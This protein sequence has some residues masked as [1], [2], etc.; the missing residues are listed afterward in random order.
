MKYLKNILIL[1]ILIVVSCTPVF[2][3]KTPY[4]IDHLDRKTQ[5]AYQL[6]HEY[7]TNTIRI[8]Q[9]TKI[10]PYSRIDT[11]LVHDH[12]KQIDVYLNKAFAHIPFREKNTR[13]IYQSARHYLN[14]AFDDYTV[15]LYALDQPIEELI[16][17][18]YRSDVS[19]YDRSR[20]PQVDEPP[21]PLIRNLSQ[22][23][24]VTQG[25]DDRYI[26][27]W[28]SHGWYYEQK[29]DRWEWQRA[30]VFQT[31]EDLFPLSFTI[32]YLMPMLENAGAHVF[33]PRERDVQTHEVIVDNDQANPATKYLEEDGWF[34]G[35]TPGFAVGKPPYPSGTN[36][37]QLG[38][39]RQTEAK[40]QATTRIHWIPEIP[41]KGHYAVY[42]SYH[43]ADSN[44]TDA[45]YT[46]NH[47]GGQT[48]FL[49]NQQMAGKTWI[50][51]GHFLFGKG[52]NPQSGSV[53][54]T[55]AGGEGGRYVT[56]DAVRFGGGMGNIERN[57]KTSGRPRY[58]EAARY[59]LQYAGMPDTL[60][61]NLNG[62]S[63]DY[64]DDYQSRGE[65]V[66]YLKGA[67][68]GPNRNRE[69]EGLGIPID[70]SL[71]FHTDAG[72]S[73]SDTV[74]GTLS[75]YC[76]TGADTTRVFPDSMSRFANRDFAD[77]LQTQIV[78]DIRA[79][80]DTVWTRRP[81]WDRGYSEAYRPNV[82]A[83]LLE[84]LSHQNF[85]DMKFGL[86]PRYRFDVSRSIYKSMLKFLAHQYQ[87]DYVVQPLP[88]SHF[89]AVFSAN[90]EVTLNWQP[91]SDPLEPTAEPDRY[92]VYTRE[93]GKGFD[94]G[95]LTDK[96]QYTIQN[97]DPGKIYS[98]K[99]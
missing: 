74:I 95:V 21:V 96:P 71:A 46:V 28:H 81:L 56:A 19:D 66:N 70:L 93:E 84:L 37:F 36:P 68:Y 3:Q 29:Y 6:M 64:N 41:E 26:A 80:Y 22:P 62:D 39:Y 79:Q 53:M 50:Y 82:P 20:M 12:S 38:S 18:V 1:S 25:L 44:I 78:D 49:I 61:Y 13:L 83:A 40:K 72:T 34:A 17:N 23:Y 7:L 75:I 85:L 16:P 91:V 47:L 45:H 97:L 8:E 55:N 52:V 98:F 35:Y 86:D 63:I 27:L 54:L 42:I 10:S 94:N 76:T 15:T 4:K 90:R 11:I 30:R 65:W 31:V 5:H 48:E 92:V 24:S 59:Y 67:P 58:V 57:G 99:V 14:R 73:V 77:I 9:P 33:V 32:P 88:V 69:A 51:L 60:V 89:Q 43:P 2:V 87:T